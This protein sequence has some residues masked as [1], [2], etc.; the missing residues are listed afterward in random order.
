MI[1]IIGAMDKEIELLLNQMTIS[2]RDEIADKIFFIGTIVGKKVVVVKSGIGKVNATITTALLLEKYSIRYVLNIGLAGGLEPAK[3]GDIVLATGISYFDVSLEAI[4]NLPFG[5]M[6]SDPMTIFPDP[7][8]LQK[9]Q[10]ILNDYGITHHIGTLVS[11]DTFVTDINTLRRILEV[12]Q[13]VIACE[14]EGMAIALTCYKFEV[15]FLSIRGISDVVN[16]VDQKEVYRDVSIEIAH[17]T[18]E[19]VIHFLEV[20]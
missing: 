12:K 9:A 11:G 5:K 3:V 14:M 15:P 20:S 16:S 13:H 19:F 2:Q 8:L 10:F 4:D 18:S 17:T 6:A 1:G 7:Q